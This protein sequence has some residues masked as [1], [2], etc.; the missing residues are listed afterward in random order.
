MLIAQVVIGLLDLLGVVLIGLLASLSINGLT[1]K[2]SGSKVTQVLSF[3][4]LSSETL[5]RQIAVVGLL[6]A[7]LLTIK[8]LVTLYFSK[9]ILYFLS[10]KA[11]ALTSELL[12]RLLNMSLLELRSRSLQEMIFAL[13]QGVRVI[14]VDVLGG[15]I[16]LLADISLLII[17][18]VSLFVVNPLVALISFCIFG[19]TGAIL[20]K[21]M[22]LKAYQ[23]GND[24]AKY[25][26][27]SQQRISEVV[28]GFREIYAKR[29]ITQK[30]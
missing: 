6:A 11:A 10:N 29:R 30:Y 12:G 1:A 7:A 4:N 21:V 9:K 17:L 25:G 28:I 3:L 5:Q 2:A 18:S 20:F 13:T 19:V 14:T 8:T 23:L 26:I 22:H 15:F 16:I 27:E 24:Q